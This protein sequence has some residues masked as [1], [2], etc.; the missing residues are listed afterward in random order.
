MKLEKKITA[1]LMRDNRLPEGCWE[2]K[3]T[4]GKSIP[5]SAFADHQINNLLKA[6]KQVLNIKIRDIGVARK[7]FD[8]ITFKKS[9]AW[10]ICCYPSNTVKCGY[11]A[12][13]ID[14][15]DW[16]NERRTC[17]RQ[18]LTEKQAQNIGFEI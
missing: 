3:R 1:E 11:T 9:P 4:T 13:A 5:F 16:Y 14:I 6:K 7:E 8:G 18:S 12:Y 2:A 10:C 15:L 17:G